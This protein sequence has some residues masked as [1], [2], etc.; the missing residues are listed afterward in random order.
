METLSKNHKK[1]VK[2]VKNENPKQAKVI[3]VPA[4]M[5][6][7]ITQEKMSQEELEELENLYQEFR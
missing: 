1:V 4:W 5:N 7:E 3:E 6:Q 2:E